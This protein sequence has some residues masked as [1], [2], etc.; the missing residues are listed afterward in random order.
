LTVLNGSEEEK[1]Q[2]KEEHE[3]EKTEILYGV[4]N[5]IS[6]GY[7]LCKMQIDGSFWGEEWTINNY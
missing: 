2:E 1:E 3:E 7:T 4:E 6:R 5:A